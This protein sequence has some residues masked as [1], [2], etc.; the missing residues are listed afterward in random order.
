MQFLREFVLQMPSKLM[1][2]DNGNY[3]AVFGDI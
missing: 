3:E 1:I 2:D